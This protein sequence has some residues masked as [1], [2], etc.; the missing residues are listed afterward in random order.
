MKHVQTKD[1]KNMK[2]FVNVY[3]LCQLS[4][5]FWLPSMSDPLALGLVNCSMRKI[6]YWGKIA[7]N[8]F[9]KW[10]NW[11]K[12]ENLD[13]YKRAGAVFMLHDMFHTYRY[14]S[15][16]QQPHLRRCMSVNIFSCLLKQRFST[17]FLSVFPFAPTQLSSLIERLHSSSCCR[18][19]R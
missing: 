13:A 17:F 7:I 14:Y 6:I 15:T 12:R 16:D 18:D 9:P 19:V 2:Q 3:Q 8:Y 5:L 4:F 1:N 10:S 11:M